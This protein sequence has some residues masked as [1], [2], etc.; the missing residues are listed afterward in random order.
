MQQRGVVEQFGHHLWIY[1]VRVSHRDAR[2]P[3]FDA[4]ISASER[5]GLLLIVQ[6]SAIA[7]CVFFSPPPAAGIRL[8]TA[9]GLHRTYT[10]SVVFRGVSVCSSSVVDQWAV[11]RVT[12]RV[13]DTVG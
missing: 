8:H 2:S 4:A 3:F 1:I 10:V 6:L 12:R 5:A 9:C 13:S 11:A 7:V